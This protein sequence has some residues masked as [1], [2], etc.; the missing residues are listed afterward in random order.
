MATSIHVHVHVHVHVQVE[1]FD[2]MQ[3]AK[4]KDRITLSD[5][6]RSGAGHTLVSILTD[7]MAFCN[8]E[9]R[10]VCVCVCECGC[11]CG[12]AW[13]HVRVRVGV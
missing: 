13:V 1:L 4:R 5:V 8:Y 7:A 6:L 11:G 10:C 2:L 9:Q 3:P 12:C